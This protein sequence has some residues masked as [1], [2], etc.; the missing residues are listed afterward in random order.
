MDLVDIV[1]DSIVLFNN[2]SKESIALGSVEVLE[3]GEKPAKAE[4]VELLAADSNPNANV[5][6]S[7]KGLFKKLFKKKISSR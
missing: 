7:K 4:E 1:G 6:E 2:G 3:V 5:D